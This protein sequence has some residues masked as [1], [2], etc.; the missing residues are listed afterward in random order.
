MSPQLLQRV[1]VLLL[2][3]ISALPAALGQ[4]GM[5]A[6]L[7][8]PGQRTAAPEFQ[9]QDSSGKAADIKSYRG[10]IVLLDFWATWC[11]GCKE[12]IPW[13]AEFERKYRDSGLRVVGVSLDDGGWKVVKPFISSASVPYRIVLGNEAVS[14]QYK[15]AQMPDT[16]IIDRQGRVAAKYVGMVDKGN[17]D[18][19]IRAVLAEH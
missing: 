6:A 15:I 12:E 9:L 18:A 17:M 10:K 5:R 4:A 1:A 2:L 16:F 11:H 14:S 13:F 3:A 19:N 8:L 7:I